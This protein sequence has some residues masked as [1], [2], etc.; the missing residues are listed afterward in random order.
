MK[1]VRVDGEGDLQVPLVGYP[2]GRVAPR[3]THTRTANIWGQ[4][5]VCVALR[6]DGWTTAPNP[7]TGGAFGL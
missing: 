5:D 1:T 2:S 6:S 7:L 3:G 4:A